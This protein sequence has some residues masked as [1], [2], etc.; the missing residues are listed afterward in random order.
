MRRRKN[1]VTPSSPYIRCIIAWVD[2]EGCRIAGSGGMGEG[3]RPVRPRRPV[4]ESEGDP[5]WDENDDRL[6][7]GLVDGGSINCN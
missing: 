5:T 1:R 4:V 3:E 6:E 2:V 7:P